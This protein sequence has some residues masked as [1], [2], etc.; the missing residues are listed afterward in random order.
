MAPALYHEGMETSQ[1][2]WFVHFRGHSLGPISTDQLKSS[3]RQG[4]LSAEDKIASAKDSTWKPLASFP[5]LAAIAA[6]AKPVRFAI[7]PPPPPSV[8]LKKKKTVA[9]QA[10]EPAS[11]TTKKTKTRKKARKKTKNPKSKSPILQAEEKIPESPKPLPERPLDFPP[12]A[13]PVAPIAAAEESL[14]ELFG[15]WQARERE[16]KLEP[17]PPPAIE[18]AAREEVETK[19]L[20]IPVLENIPIP[21]RPP[22]AKEEAE[23]SSAKEIRIE[24]K[25]SLTK[26]FLFVSILLL[27]LAGIGIYAWS[28]KKTRDPEGLRPPDPS[29]PTALPPA[30]GDPFPSLKAPT[31]PRRD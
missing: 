24:L 19:P 10:I 7:A 6:A 15:E 8:L 27:L 11:P 23:K 28:A 18:P 5:E 29:S 1:E 2:R 12:A 25:L 3:L 21:E 22:L 16:A 17:L 4:E 20:S 13:A 30:T 31:S 26:Q 14:L 9:S